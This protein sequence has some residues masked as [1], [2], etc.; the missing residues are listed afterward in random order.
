ML[1]RFVPSSIA[2][3]SRAAAGLLVVCL[4]TGC[5]G[6]EDPIRVY[7]TPGI[8]T[9][10][11]TDSG[12]PSPPEKPSVAGTGTPP[13]AG[14][15]TPPFARGMTGL[16]TPAE[17]QRLLGAIAVVENDANGDFWFFKFIG[18]VAKVRAAE[19]GFRQ[20]LGS[21]SLAGGNATWTVPD[22]WT[23]RPASGMRYA[24]LIAPNGVEA[25]VTTFGI[26]GSRQTQLDENFKRWR[27]Q[28]GGQG[29]AGVLEDLTIPGAASTALLAVSTP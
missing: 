23:E 21:I 13:F 6:D 2:H 8:E 1:P 17:P 9:T 3:A 22:G 11:A 26:R 25:T 10:V 18:P 28:V 15:T 20:W 19:D 7:K 29:E 27:G 12:P 4:L 14:G 16:Q 5:G 24:T